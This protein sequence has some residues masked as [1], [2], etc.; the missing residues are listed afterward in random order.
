MTSWATIAV[1]GAACAAGL[2]TTAAASPRHP[3]WGT[4]LV[5]GI[6][7]RAARIHANA[8]ANPANQILSYGGGRGPAG[9]VTGQPKVYLVVWGTGWGEQIDGPN[10][11]DYANDPY[12][13]IPLLTSFFS[14]LGT[15]GEAWSSVSTE[16]CASGTTIVEPTNATTCASG[17]ARVPYPGSSVFGGVWYDTVTPSVASPSASQLAGAAQDA[18]EYFGNTSTDA[19]YMVLSPPGSQPDG[20]NNGLTSGNFCG[21]H[22]YAYDST[23]G[24]R[25]QQDST[26]PDVAFINLPYVPDAGFGCGANAVN[27]GQGGLTDGITIVAGHEY[28][29]WLTDPFPAAGWS[30]VVTGDEIADNCMW[31]TPGHQGAMTDLTLATGAFAVQSLWS[32]RGSACVTSA[33]SSVSVTYARPI[34]SIQSL[35]IT[36]GV[37]ASAGI[38]GRMLH[39]AAAG[40]PTG[41]RINAG[42]GRVTGRPLAASRRYSVRISVTDTYGP[43]T[44]RII[45]WTVAPAVLITRPATQTSAIG[46]GAALNLHATD[47]IAHRRIRFAASGLPSGM[48]L[49]PTTGRITGRVTARHGAYLVRLVVRDNG[50]GWSTTRFT[51]R[52]R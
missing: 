11:V 22:D 13:E 10:G 23:T 38:R 12:H 43:P 28:A 42:T 30:N 17:T 51:W 36:F 19:V 52:V 9:V 29:E 18:A 4:V 46:A 1:A 16:Y 26:H 24:I 3:H 21:W 31:I 40:L 37:R 50:G 2:A 49:D 7:G 34:T 35:P 15:G 33:I 27:P 39:Y 45:A 20:F 47:R 32:N 5:R 14:G 25:T 6:A 41:M 8:S 48:H 44:V